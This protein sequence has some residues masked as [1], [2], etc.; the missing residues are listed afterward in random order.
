[1]LPELL[2]KPRR[3]L[4]ASHEHGMTAA[5]EMRPHVQ[6]KKADG[7]AGQECTARSREPEENGNSDSV[8][9]MP[10]RSHH[11]RGDQGGD[12]CRQSHAA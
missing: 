9:V 6:M 8:A 7:S 1:M 5:P 4:A 11:C 3:A 10:S 2:R 12:A